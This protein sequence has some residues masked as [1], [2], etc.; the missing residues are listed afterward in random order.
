MPRTFPDSIISVL[1]S[2]K[3]AIYNSGLLICWSQNLKWSCLFHNV[4]CCKFGEYP[5]NAFQNSVLTKLQNVRTVYGC[6]HG[7]R[8]GQKHDSSTHITG[9]KSI[10]I[11]CHNWYNT[12]VKQHITIKQG[13]TSLCTAETH[14][15]ASI[16]LWVPSKV[17]YQITLFLSVHL[18]THIRFLFNRS[19]IPE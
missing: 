7:R 3:N 5:A 17:W 10:K 11:K 8:I 18:N 12:Y 2:P 15:L 1:I 16:I 9:V 14:P 6:T 19:I 13:N 4:Y